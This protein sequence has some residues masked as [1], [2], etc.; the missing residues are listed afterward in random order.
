[1]I[2]KMNEVLAFDW[3]LLIL[4]KT[5]F[6]AAFPPLVTSPRWEFTQELVKDGPE[7]AV[8]SSL[9]PH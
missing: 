6:A 5:Y 8:L 1:M 7:D 4:R 2:R 3:F 9:F